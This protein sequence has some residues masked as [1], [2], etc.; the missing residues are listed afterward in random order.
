MTVEAEAG[1]DLADAA[2]EEFDPV[3]AVPLAQPAVGRHS[4]AHIRHLPDHDT[5]ARVPDHPDPDLDLDLFREILAVQGL[6]LTRIMEE[7]DGL[8]IGGKAAVIAKEVMIDIKDIPSITVVITK[9]G[10]R[11]YTLTVNPTIGTIEKS[12]NKWRNEE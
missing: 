6:P 10:D 11:L 3:D 9:I 7:V 2:N 1:V 8:I 12:R 4:H 5:L